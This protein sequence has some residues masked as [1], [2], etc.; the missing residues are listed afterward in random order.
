MTH[1]RPTTNAIRPDCATITRK[2]SYVTIRCNLSDTKVEG[3]AHKNTSTSIHNYS[4]GRR[5]DGICSHAICI[6]CLASGS[7]KGNNSTLK[8]NLY[9]GIAIRQIHVSR[10]IKSKMGTKQIKKRGCH[11]RGS[12]ASYQWRSCTG[13]KAIYISR[14]R[15]HSQGSRIHE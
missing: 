6:P 4:K 12:D 9:D 10:R 2:R 15:M 13:V 7:C 14:N 1:C 8:G 3:V 11:T 5:K